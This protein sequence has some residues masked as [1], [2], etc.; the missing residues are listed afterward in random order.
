MVA[1]IRNESHKATHHILLQ[2]VQVISVDD[3]EY[4]HKVCERELSGVDHDGELIDSRFRLPMVDAT[5]EP[6]P[7]STTAHQSLF[8]VKY[9]LRLKCKLA[10]C[11]SVKVDL[12]VTV[13]EMAGA[14]S[15]AAGSQMGQTQQSDIPFARFVEQ[16]K[17]IP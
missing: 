7:P 14:E 11:K 4:S 17:Q 8:A 9:V 10:I 6:V 2:L 12:P 1:T 16:V 5:G 3:G 15:V 13:V